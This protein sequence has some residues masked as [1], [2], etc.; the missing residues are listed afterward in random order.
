MQAAKYLRDARHLDKFMFTL[1]DELFY[2][3]LETRY[4]PHAEYRA[5]VGDLLKEI[6]R[7]WTIERDGFWFFV[8][9]DRQFEL[10][11]QGWKVHVSA[12]VENAQS[13]L[14]RAARIALSNNVTFKFALDRNVLATMSSKRWARG[15]SGKFITMYPPDLSAFKKLLEDLYAELQADEG[16][17][18]LSD[19]RYKDCRVLYYRYGGMFRTGRTDIKGEQVLVLFNSKGEPVPDRRTPYF[20]PPPWATDPFPTEKTEHK[21][22]LLN[23]RFAVKKAIAFSNSGGIYIADDRQTGN[24]VIIKEARAHTAMDDR[25]NDAIKMLKREQEIL[26]LLR[27]TDIAPKFIDSFY[28]WENFFLVEEYL[29]GVDIREIMLTQSPLMQVRPSLE[30]SRRYYQIARRIYQG[31]AH[32]IDVLHQKGIVFGD[33]NAKNIRIDPSTHA[34]RLIDFEGCFK[35]A[36]EEP[37]YLFTPGFKS[38]ASIRKNTQGF[39]DDLFGLAANMLY[40]L[41][42]IPAISTLRPDVFDKLLQIILRDVGWS[43]TGLYNIISRLAKNELTGGRVSELLDR[44]VE[45]LPPSYTDDVDIDYCEKVSQE[46]GRFILANIRTDR[47]DALFPADPFLHRTNAIS[48]GF[49]AAG[50]LYTLK[51]CD[52]EI[53]ASASHWFEQKLDKVKRDELPP[54]LLTGAAGIAWSLWELG[55]EERALEFMKT[56]NE[57][58]LL[59]DH[60]SYLYGMAGIGMANLHFYLRTH[61]SN[62]LITATDLADSL[63]ESAAENESGIYWKNDGLI[64]VGYGYGQSGVALFLLRLFQLTGKEKFL[65]EGRRALEFDLAHGEER[66]PGVLSF[67]RGPG[68]PTVVPYI[69]EGSAG[70][71]KVAMRYGIWDERLEMMLLDAHRKYSGFVGFLY[72]LGSFVDVFTDAYLFSQNQKFL[73]MAKRPV[74]GIRDLY[75]MEHPNG[76]A[77]PGDNLFR[78]SCDYATGI[79]GVLRSLHRFTHLEPADFVL[80]EVAAT[81]AQQ[82]ELE[83]AKYLVQDA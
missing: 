37:T 68:D 69:E 73:Q 56:A 66:E 2:E 40:M 35:P 79:A 70:I 71:A 45:I 38:A 11:L 30:D 44:P 1:I 33:L 22:I 75:L 24:E 52:F 42:P 67:P 32:A 83:T 19:K 82:S 9:P 41:F 57:G 58:A 62:Y 63:L 29:D 6:A 60:H 27:D 4:H 53:P 50:V 15:G 80:D 16:P 59:K 3:P 12:A 65:F 55:Y 21:E 74:T 10:P 43:Q 13:I 72:G 77:V 14:A 61:D 18:I 8:H 36:E 78:I 49:G 17:Y 47:D 7:D 20:A 28:G 48:L 25:G 46:F 23:G 64:H 39:E 81:A 5:I 31:F 26:E 34:V 51:K 76:W 54:G